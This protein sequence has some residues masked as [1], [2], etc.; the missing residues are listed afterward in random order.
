MFPATG[1]LARGPVA[2]GVRAL[3]DARAWF[4][5]PAETDEERLAFD[6]YTLALTTRIWVWL[7]LAVASMAL[8]WWPLDAIVFADNPHAQRIYAGYRLG[9]IVINLGFVAA[10]PHLGVCRRHPQL[11]ATLAA[12]LELALTGLVL[13]DA[14]RGSVLWISYAFATPQLSAVLFVTLRERVLA[15]AFLSASIMGA[16]L[17]HPLS[18]LASPGAAA[19]VSFLVF[20]DLLSIGFGQVVFVLLRRGFYLQR[21]LD[22]EHRRLEQLAGR[23]EQRVTEQTRALRVA[24]HRAQDARSTQREEL[25]RD[26]HDGLGQ[27]LT[28]LRLLVGIG[29][30]SMRSPTEGELLSELASSVDRVQQ[31]LRRVLVALRPALLDEQGLVEALRVLVRELERRAGLP[32][33]LSVSEALPEPVPV[34][35]GVALYHIAQEG[36]HNALRHARATSIKVGLDVRAGCLV[37]TVADDGVGI[38]PNRVGAGMGTSG[39]RERAYTLGGSAHWEQRNGTLLTVTMPIPEPT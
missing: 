2:R 27:E 12:S 21:R 5:D 30:A 24:N 19:A 22:L 17:V 10:L 4:A 26:L 8:V 29:R 32:I 31:S 28:S 38:P 11:T 14:G 1:A 9:I 33:H 13:A 6:E 23:L 3:A 39:V 15:V 35:Q 16:W 37:L 25:A 18:G 34:E 20:C 36:L 7:G